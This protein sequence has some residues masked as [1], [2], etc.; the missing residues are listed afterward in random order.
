MITNEVKFIFQIL[1][2]SQA[3]ERML[4]FILNEQSDEFNNGFFISY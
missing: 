4:N 2:F 1:I 3:Q